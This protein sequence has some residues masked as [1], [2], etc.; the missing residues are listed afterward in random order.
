MR[1]TS[2][3]RVLTKKSF[4]LYLA[5]L[6]LFW[7]E[8]IYPFIHS[9]LWNTITENDGLQ[10]ARILI[11]ADPQLIGYQN[12][13][14]FM[15]PIARFDSDR[16]LSRGFFY[17]LRHGRPDLI[18]FLGD[19]VDEGVEAS[20]E[21]F[22]LT[23]ARF[24]NI[25]ASY[26]S[27]QRIYVAG[28]NDIGGEAEQVITTLRNRFSKRFPNVLSMRDLGLRGVAV[29]EMNVFNGELRNLTAATRDDKLSLMLSHAPIIRSFGVGARQASE[30]NSD[31]IL[32]AHDHTAWS[33]TRNRAGSSSS[34]ERTQIEGEGVIEKTIGRDQPVIELQTPTCS[35]R[36]GVPDMGYGLLTLRTIDDE[37]GKGK[38]ELEAKYTVL[39]LP[40]RYPQLLSYLVI[41][42]WLLI[43]TAHRVLYSCL[44]SIV[45]TRNKT[46]KQNIV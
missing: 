27:I 10:A 30:R 38:L 24:D 14:L 6:L 40:G 31:L 29:D 4:V 13:P 42:V 1:K 11:V 35:Y 28:D 45:L 34:F 37:T 33:Y 23:M 8:A 46:V 18:I 25:F 3:L 7:N 32:S 19:L 16:Y 12:E 20:T 5:V 21:E 41:L 9:S 26:K 39:W 36:M 17:A 15:G 22:D 44:R 43:I 2:P